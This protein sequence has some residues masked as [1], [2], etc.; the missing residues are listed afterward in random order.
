ML[1]Y[2][3]SLRVPVCDGLILSPGSSCWWLLIPPSYKTNE[4]SWPTHNFLSCWSTST[5]RVWVNIYLNSV[6]FISII[7][8]IPVLWSNY[9][10]FDCKISFLLWRYAM[11]RNADFETVRDIKEKLCYIRWTKIIIVWHTFI[12][13]VWLLLIGSVPLQLWLQ[14]GVS[15]GTWD[16]HPC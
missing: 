4:R 8:P 7:L 6:S 1:K 5:S 12:K 11:N 9:L 13:S 14:K 15:I 16:Y 10:R 2:E 3:S